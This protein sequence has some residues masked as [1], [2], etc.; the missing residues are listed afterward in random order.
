MPTQRVPKA[1]AKAHHDHKDACV[2]IALEKK[3]PQ[4]YTHIVKTLRGY[5]WGQIPRVPH[6]TAYEALWATQLATARPHFIPDHAPR[7]H[8]D[9]LWPR[10]EEH[11]KD[12]E[13][14]G[15]LNAPALTGCPRT[16]HTPP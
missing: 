10:L 6:D 3:R 13:V 15:A 4:D 2:S 14:V 5:C 7:S 11:G 8:L 16:A 9:H 1:Q 12:R